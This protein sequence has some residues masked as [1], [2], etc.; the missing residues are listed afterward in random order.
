MRA[1]TLDRFISI[2]RLTENVAASGAVSTTWTEIAAV[3]A[4]LVQQSETEA[5]T[6][7]GE[8]ETTSVIFRIRYL[9][10]M[11]LADRVIYAGSAYGLQ[12]I[13]E[14]GRRRG[15]ELRAARR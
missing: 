4:E 14:I 11:T 1:G 2:E 8:G 13:A 3:R 6:G 9:P 7:F 12:E 10:G 5:L 15:L